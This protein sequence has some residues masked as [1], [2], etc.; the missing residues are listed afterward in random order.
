MGTRFLFRILSFAVG[1]DDD[2]EHPTQEEEEQRMTM[3][4]LDP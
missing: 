1:E 4:W 2:L 3:V